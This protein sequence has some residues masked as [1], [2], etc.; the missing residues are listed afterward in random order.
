MGAVVGKG[1]VDAIE[2]DQETAVQVRS[3]KTG[4]LTL[5]SALGGSSASLDPSSKAAVGLFF[6]QPEEEIVEVQKLIKLADYEC[7][8]ITNAKGVLSFFYVRRGA[9]NLW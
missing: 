6:P 5:V 7:M 9:S 8:I 3:K 1:K 4:E 2:I